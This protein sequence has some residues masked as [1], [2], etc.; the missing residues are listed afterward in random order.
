MNLVQFHLRTLH[1]ISKL[2]LSPHLWVA[3]CKLLQI[4]NDIVLPHHL[5]GQLLN[6]RLQILYHLLIQL[7]LLIISRITQRLH[8]CHILASV[9]L[10]LVDLIFKSSH[11]WFGLQSLLSP[12]LVKLHIEEFSLSL[13]VSPFPLFFLAVE[14][15]FGL[16]E[17]VF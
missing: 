14:Q 7:T 6:P 12:V 15:A 16:C 9:L 2:L 4:P 13:V 10:S 11:A 3:H 5:V 17:S 1:H 8:I